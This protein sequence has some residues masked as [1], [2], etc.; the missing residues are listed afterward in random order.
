MTHLL[1]DADAS[2]GAFRRS[3]VLTM[4]IDAWDGGDGHG[5]G[6]EHI[7]TAH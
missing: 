1:H 5:M 6:M 3:V 7:G 4:D 2:R